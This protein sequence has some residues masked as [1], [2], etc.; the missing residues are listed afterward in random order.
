MKSN[1]KKKNKSI[2]QKKIK[3]TVSETIVGDESVSPTVDEIFS[4]NTRRGN[5]FWHA[6]NATHCC[7]DKTYRV[8]IT[9]IYQHSPSG[10]LDFVVGTL[11]TGSSPVE[12]FS[13]LLTFSSRVLFV[14]NN[15]A[16]RRSSRPS[17]DES[18]LPVSLVCR[19][20]CDA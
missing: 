19:H 15:V 14:V 4:R 12:S 17:W 16:S 6:T 8:R 1:G 7:A 10:E 2:D 11:V 20:I 9:L 3:N 5:R 18:S 13:S